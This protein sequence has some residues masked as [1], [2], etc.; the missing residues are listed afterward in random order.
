MPKES[1]NADTLYAKFQYEF[2]RLLSMNSLGTRFS[3]ILG[4]T[5]FQGT[6]KLENV[7]M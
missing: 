6:P 5:L 3:K 1:G 2:N 4:T 7:A